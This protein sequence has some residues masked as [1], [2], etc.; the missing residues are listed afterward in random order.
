MPVLGGS[1]FASLVRKLYIYSKSLPYGTIRVKKNNSIRIKSN[2]IKVSN[3]LAKNFK[4]LRLRSLAHERYKQCP[5]NEFRSLG[6][7][8]QTG[9]IQVDSEEDPHLLGT[10]SSNTATSTN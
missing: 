6:P 8:S 2:P 3:L 1:C 9:T 7:D 10:L 4:T 5:L